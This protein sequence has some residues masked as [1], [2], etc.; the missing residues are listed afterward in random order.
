[1]DETECKAQGGKWDSATGSCTWIE[2][3]KLKETI[4]RGAQCGER[5]RRQEIVI[6]PG[7]VPEV[8]K[9]ELLNASAVKRSL[10]EAS[11]KPIVVKET[12]K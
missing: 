2:Q 9:T 8:V 6:N 10:P 4:S 5:V 3:I 7:D 12:T 1:M 11:V